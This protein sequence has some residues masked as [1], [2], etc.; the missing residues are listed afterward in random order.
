MNMID[1]YENIFEDEFDANEFGEIGSEEQHLAVTE[2][3][4]NN[5]NKNSD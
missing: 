4:N 3:V 5:E 1:D 2:R